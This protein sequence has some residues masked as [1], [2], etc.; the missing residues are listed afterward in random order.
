MT[1]TPLGLQRL[2]SQPHHD[3]SDQYVVERPDELGGE[4]VVRLRLPKATSADRVLLRYERDGEPRGVEA[5][6]DEETESDVWW[7][8]EFPLANPVTRYRW[9]L[10]GGSAG[11]TWV[12]SLFKM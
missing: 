9:L 5:T 10:S 3:G 11:Y 7:R 8:A 2:L 12:M 6:V 1:V 4:A